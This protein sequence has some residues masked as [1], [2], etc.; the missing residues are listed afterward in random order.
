MYV[1][2]VLCTTLFLSSILHCATQQRNTVYFRGNQC[3]VSEK[4]A[5]KNYS[6]FAKSYIRTFSGANF[7]ITLKI[8]LYSI[9]VSDLRFCWWFK[10]SIWL[11]LKAFIQY[12][13]EM[14]YRNVVVSP[15]I[16]ICETLKKSMNSRLVGQII[17]TFN[18]SVPGLA[19]DCPY[20]VASS[21]FC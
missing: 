13:Y 20:N 17:K 12:K 6:C 8:P 4:Y 5:Y 19:H 16:E 14:I 10:T 3:N 15:E 9:Y 18:E 2:K 11:Q 1:F 7:H 21:F